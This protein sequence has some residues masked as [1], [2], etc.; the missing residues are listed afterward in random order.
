MIR[1]LWSNLVKWGWYYAHENSTIGPVSGYDGGIDIPSSFRLDVS[2]AR[3]GIVVI[4]RRHD[5]NMLGRNTEIVHVLPN[6]GDIAH[7]IGAI[8][9]MEVLR[10]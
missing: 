9:A 8:A 10:S 4:V 1:R 7:D 3:G 6:C 5:G 2:I